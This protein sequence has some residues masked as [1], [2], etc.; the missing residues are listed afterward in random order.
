[1]IEVTGAELQRL[2]GDVK[3]LQLQNWNLAQSNSHML[4]VSFGMEQVFC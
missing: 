4:A 2:R 1:M 3:K